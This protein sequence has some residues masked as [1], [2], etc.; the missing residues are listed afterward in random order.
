[1]AGNWILRAHWMPTCKFDWNESLAYN[2]ELG[3]CNLNGDETK[4]VLQINKSMQT[5]ERNIEIWKVKS[6]F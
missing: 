6:E 5:L 4:T 1:M 3:L 2:D